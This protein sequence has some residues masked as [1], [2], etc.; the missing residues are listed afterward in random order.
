MPVGISVPLPSRPRETG[1]TMP[2]RPRA[3]NA[4]DHDSFGKI[5]ERQGFRGPRQAHELRPNAWFATLREYVWQ[6]QEKRGTLPDLDVSEILEWADA[7]HAHTGEWPAHNSGSIP[8]APGETWLAVEAALCYGLRNLPGGW[9]IL[10]LLAEH[11]GLY[12]RRDPNFTILQI[13]TWADDW[14]SRTGEWPSLDSGKIPDSGGINWNIVDGALRLGR[15]EL[16]VG[17]SLSRLLAAER[18]AI[19]S[20]H[21]LSLTEEQILAW[22]DAYHSQTGGW[23]QKD[24]GPLAR[25]EGINWATI[26]GALRYGRAGLAAGSSLARLLA[27]KRGVA[28]R[29]EQPPLDE[30]TILAWA[31]AFHLR[32]GAW[33]MASQQDVIPE[34]ERGVTWQ[35]VDR[36]LRRGQRGLSGRSSLARLLAL[37]RGVRIRTNL[38]SFEE[39][40]ILA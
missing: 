24:S 4:I 17:S 13:L 11:R 29:S 33:P 1:I 5:F 26:D 35:R 30:N 9:T 3:V 8:E 7:H 34:A 37:E 19:Q 32:T 10:R 25:S 16:P 40:R 31:D 20:V 22:A 15:G 23:P 12:N 28:H 27:A 39:I 38:P 18:G 6:D 36:A 2:K 14:R 21:H